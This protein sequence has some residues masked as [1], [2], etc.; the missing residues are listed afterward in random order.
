MGWPGHDNAPHF[1][2]GWLVDFS[3]LRPAR[4]SAGNGSTG[5][6]AKLSLALLVLGLLAALVVFQ[7][8]VK[9]SLSKTLDRM[10]RSAE[11]EGRIIPDTMLWVGD[12]LS[13]PAREKT[14]SR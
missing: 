12:K 14:S 3:G 10:A 9:S 5:R 6:F 7:P 1:E 13:R 8:T 11:A 4:R 2:I